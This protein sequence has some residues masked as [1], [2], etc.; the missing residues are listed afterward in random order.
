[1]E[2]F[3]SWIERLFMQPINSKCTIIAP[4]ELCYLA[5]FNFQLY[6]NVNLTNREPGSNAP[7]PYFKAK[8]TFVGKL[9]LNDRCWKRAFVLKVVSRKHIILKK[10][11]VI[12]YPVKSL[13]LQSLVFTWLC[14]DPNFSLL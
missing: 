11:T 12:L 7:P 9:H 2:Q 14:R 13:Q 3:K 1:M 4:L 10:T 8:V 6:A 5:S